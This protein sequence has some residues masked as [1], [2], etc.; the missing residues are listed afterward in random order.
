M[1]SNLDDHINEGTA[2]F[3]VLEGFG[4][5][6]DEIE[7]LTKARDCIQTDMPNKKWEYEVGSLDKDEY[8]IWYDFEANKTT[9]TIF[10][11]KPIPPAAM[12]FVLSY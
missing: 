3:C 7:A 11:R 4:A 12:E 6:W 5:N 8:E 10:Y 1:G 2:Y 9:Y